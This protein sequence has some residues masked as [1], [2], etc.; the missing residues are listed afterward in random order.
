MVTFVQVD[1]SKLSTER[2]GRRGRVSYPLIKGF[3]E[4]N[5]KMAKLDT[6]GLTKNP[7]Y[8]RSVLYSYIKSH[9]LPIKIFS[10]QGDMHFMRL[11]M[12]NN[13]VVDPNWKYEADQ[14]SEGSKALLRNEEAVPI[15]A[16]E[17][18]RRFSSEKG[19]IT[20]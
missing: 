20:K 13:G 7:N 12:D 17:V 10:L 16:D 6:T 18:A 15:T 2:L 11:D 8:L 4:M 5:I 3:L 9:K 14:A 19:Q 1:P